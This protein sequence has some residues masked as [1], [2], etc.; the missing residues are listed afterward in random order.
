[1]GQINVFTGSG[2]GKTPAAV[3]EALMR[4]AGGDNVVI[5]QFLK[6]KGLIDSELLNKLEPQLRIFRFEKSDSNFDKLN[7]S[8]QD[9]EIINIKNGLNFARKVLATGQCD[10]LIL[11][12]ILG[13]VDNG[14]LKVAELKEMLSS[15]PDSM[16][17]IMTGIKLDDEILDIADNVSSISNI[18]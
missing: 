13:I 12:E 4:V 2:H 17:V 8:Q 5:I 14:I 18:K 3:G 16:D 11:D 6:G 10:L 7:K 1:M 9:E 15:R